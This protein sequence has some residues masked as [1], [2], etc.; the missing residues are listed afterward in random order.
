MTNDTIRNVTGAATAR[1]VLLRD[2]TA[3]ELERVSG[4]S[5]G[6]AGGVISG[7][8]SVIIGAWLMQQG[9]QEL[10]DLN[11]PPGCPGGLH[12]IYAGLCS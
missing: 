2:A 4:G 12:G 9:S 10:N 8:T 1:V 5:G 3:A 6:V 11:A 7:G